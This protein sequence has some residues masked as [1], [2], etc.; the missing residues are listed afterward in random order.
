MLDDQRMMTA[1]RRIRESIKRLDR[2]SK[3]TLSQFTANSDHYAIAEHH[4]RTMVTLLL[5]V[6]RYLIAKQGVEKP[7]NYEHVLEI[8]AHDGVLPRDYVESNRDIVT[9]RNRLVHSC[10]VAPQELYLLIQ[11]KTQVFEGFC[12]YIVAYLKGVT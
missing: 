8:L 1:I 11:D 3:L 5:D 9:Y 10:D 12:R 4:L 6:S 2:M 7:R